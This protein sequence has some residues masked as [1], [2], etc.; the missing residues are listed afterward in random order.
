MSNS[1]ENFFP[2][3]AAPASARKL[4]H[5]RLLLKSMKSVK[6]FV[7]GV[8]NCFQKV[9]ALNQSVSSGFC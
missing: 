3:L 1:A 7:L 2:W 4:V 5:F 6:Y 8:I 9:G